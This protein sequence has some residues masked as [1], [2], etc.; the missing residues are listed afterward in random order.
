MQN[1]VEIERVAMR[2][3]YDPFMEI[4]KVMCV[5]PDDRA[6]FGRLCCL[7]M[8]FD[9]HGTAWF[10]PYMECDYNYYLSL[11]PLKDVEMID[12]CIKALEA[13]YSTKEA[14]AKFKFIRK[15]TRRR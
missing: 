2:I 11:K 10:E 5:F 1:K 8:W 6:C 13:R 12:R 9:G 7:T 14:P 4:E 15:I 3:E